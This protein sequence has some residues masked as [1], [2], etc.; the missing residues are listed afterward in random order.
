MHVHEVECRRI[1]DVVM[2]GKL[3]VEST[4]DMY[5]GGR[6]AVW[7]RR[8]TDDDGSFP[9]RC[10]ASASPRTSPNR[11]PKTPPPRQRAALICI[12]GIRLTL[13]LVSPSASLRPHRRNLTMTRTDGGPA[14][15]ARPRAQCWALVATKCQSDIDE[16]TSCVGRTCNAVCWSEALCL[17]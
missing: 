11:P 2:Q 13:C 14:K 3:V 12:F 15:N 8:E 17:W 10:G 7:Q 5:V 16:Y 4:C 9:I 6:Y 1:C